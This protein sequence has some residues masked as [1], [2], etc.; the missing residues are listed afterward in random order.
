[1]FL[2]S[3]AHEYVVLMPSTDSL[4]LDEPCFVPWVK[5]LALS[6]YD[7]EQLLEGRYLSANHIAA[8]QN[9]LKSAYPKQHGLQDT[10]CLSSNK[11]LDVPEQFK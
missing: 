10:C 3:F 6:M 5:G 11:W 8:G 9:L 2:F 4:S 7:G 1:V